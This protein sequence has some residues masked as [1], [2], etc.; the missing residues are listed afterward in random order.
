[1]SAYYLGALGPE[2]ESAVEA[3][4][5]VCAD[6]LA[7]YDALGPLVDQLDRLADHKPDL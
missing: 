6:C 3:H 5:A 2:E 1:L 7:E 4:L